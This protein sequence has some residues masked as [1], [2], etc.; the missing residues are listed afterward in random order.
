M[1]RGRFGPLALIAIGIVAGSL[2]RAAEAPLPSPGQGPRPLAIESPA[3]L[4]IGDHERLLVIAPHPDDET[5]GAGGLI[6]RVL[7]RGGTV[8]VVLVTAGD[9]Y[10][11][12][13]TRETHNPRPRA[14]DFV[15][16]GERRI[17]ESRAAMRNLDHDRVRLQLLGFPDGGLD[18]LLR[19]HWA[20][21]DPE[22]SATTG[23]SDP[24]YDAEAVDP[25]V[26][27]DGADLRRE[28][29]GLIRRAP[30]T[31]VALP[32]PLD[33]HPDHRAAGIFGLLAVGDWQARRA[34]TA[35]PGDDA[36]GGPRIFAYLV[37]WPDWPPGA[38]A[39]RVAEGDAKKPLA[40]PVD[41]P[42]HG[43]GPV[44]LQLTE[45]ERLNKRAAMERYATQ[46]AVMPRMLAAFVRGAEPFVQ[47]GAADVR[48]ADA[49]V[50]RDWPAPSPTPAR[51]SPPSPSR[52]RE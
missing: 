1:T 9:A 29:A 41:F 16:L 11:E 17:K 20:R 43:L 4:A 5:I 34:R 51:F 28:L 50:P 10:V 22:R 7:E 18:A 35:T 45:R 2:A 26:P 49:L 31:L 38:E 30:P 46:Q 52:E 13:V 40:R 19:A 32:D 48:A 3:P 39:E 14:A 12:A 24:P 33:Q 47:L 21:R 15:A 25:S 36:T 23:A 8:R 6:Q 27:Y 37:H 44:S 42:R